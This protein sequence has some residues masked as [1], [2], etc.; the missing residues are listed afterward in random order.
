MNPNQGEQPPG[1]SM[2][3]QAR[4]AAEQAMANARENY[5]NKLS[6]ILKIEDTN[7]RTQQIALLN[8]VVA[9]KGS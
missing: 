6:E 8:R 2:Q 1:K 4:Q 9:A 5:Q 3:E 7:K